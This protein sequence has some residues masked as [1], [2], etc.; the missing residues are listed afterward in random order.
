MQSTRA[1]RSDALVCFDRTGNVRWQIEPD[2]QLTFGGERFSGPWKLQ[3]VAVSRDPHR[4]KIWAAYSHNT[5]RP[6]FVMEITAD[7]QYAIRYVQ[8]G[9]V[10]AISEWQTGGDDLLAVGGVDNNHAR[11][12][13]A[14]IS[15]TEAPAHSPA[16]AG[17]RDECQGCPGD[18]PRAYILLPNSEVAKVQH[19]TSRVVDI[20]PL[21]RQLKITVAEGPGD[22]ASVAFI[23]SDLRV[24]SCQPTDRYWLVHKSLELQHLIGHTA[25]QCP[26]RTKAR[27]VDR[28]MPGQ[29]WQHMMVAPQA[30][31][32]GSGTR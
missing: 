24:T 5:W 29:G 30:L 25:D 16:P 18:L 20:R 4:M 11:P 31:G 8:S 12:S 26:E 10:W 3:T 23:S 2:T 17:S 13:I 28:W 32:G 15:L 1:Q 19:D 22:A 14:L 9:W 6:A 7:G 27:E 21:P